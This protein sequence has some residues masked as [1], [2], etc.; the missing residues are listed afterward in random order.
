MSKSIIARL[1]V[2]AATL[3]VLCM[4]IKTDNQEDKISFE[5]KRLLSSNKELIIDNKWSSNVISTVGDRFLIQMNIY[6]FDDEFS[7]GSTAK[8]NNNDALDIENIQIV[9]LEDGGGKY[10]KYYQTYS[11]LIDVI[12]KNE[13]TYKFDDLNTEITGSKSNHKI[14]LGKF[15]LTIYPKNVFGTD[16]EFMIGE[17]SMNFYEIIDCETQDYLK[18]YFYTEIENKVKEDVVIKAIRVSNDNIIDLEKLDKSITIKP[19]EKKEIEVPFKLDRNIFNCLYN[20]EILYTVGD[21]NKKQISG[22]N[23]ISRSLDKNGVAKLV[24]DNTIR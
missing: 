21:Q 24:E 18:S 7:E 22:M 23:I 13:G 11:L 16:L 9:K 12:P 5:N 3:I 19:G 14:N 10:N 15:Y 6:D 8:I 2:I 4:F 17:T 1:I 20:T